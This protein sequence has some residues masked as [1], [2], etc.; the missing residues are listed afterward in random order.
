MKN[1]VSLLKYLQQKK[2]VSAR[3]AS[4]LIVDKQEHADKV[5][6]LKA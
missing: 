1:Y 3:I 6:E 5:E 4:Y 2:I